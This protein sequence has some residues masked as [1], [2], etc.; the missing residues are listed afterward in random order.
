MVRDQI[1]C[2]LCASGVSAYMFDSIWANS[3]KVITD[4]DA[5]LR[6]L[7]TRLDCILIVENSVT[8]FI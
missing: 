1:T 5:N 2:F 6:K 7:V 4:I 3:H 8:I